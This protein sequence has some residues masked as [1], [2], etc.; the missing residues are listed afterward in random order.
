MAK[1]PESPAPLLSVS[2][3]ERDQKGVARILTCFAE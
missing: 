1:T 3:N 2:E